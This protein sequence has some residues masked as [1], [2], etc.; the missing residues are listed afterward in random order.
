[1]PISI[2]V[3]DERLGHTGKDSGNVFDAVCVWRVLGTL[4][5]D[6]YGGAIAQALVTAQNPCKGEE[7]YRNGSMKT[8]GYPGLDELS[9]S[10]VIIRKFYDQAHGR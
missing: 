6:S 2:A 10:H 1:M 5:S 9:Q 8:E 7:L 3:L 4:K